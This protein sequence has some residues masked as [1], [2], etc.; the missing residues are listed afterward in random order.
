MLAE[1]IRAVLDA[2]GTADAAGTNALLK[3]VLESVWYKK[4]KKTKPADFQLQ[5]VLRAL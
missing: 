3:S 4:E 5:F 1:K 2:Y